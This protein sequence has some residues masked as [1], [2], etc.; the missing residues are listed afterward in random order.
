MPQKNV[1]SRSNVPNI[2][3]WPDKPQ[4]IP[5]LFFWTKCIPFCSF[6]HQTSRGHLSD[7]LNSQQYT[8]RFPITFLVWNHP[9]TILSTFPLLQNNSFQN[10]TNVDSAIPF[11]PRFC[12]NISLN[13]VSTILSHLYNFVNF[14]HTILVR[15]S[16]FKIYYFKAI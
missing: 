5:S 15:P 3:R 7:L 6:H 9:N 1:P 11:I 10:D 4:N 12:P 16:P 8:N 13:Q 2:F 14:E